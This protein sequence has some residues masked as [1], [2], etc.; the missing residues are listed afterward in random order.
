M[1]PIGSFRDLLTVLRR[2]AWLVALVLA[3]GLPLVVMFALSRPRIYEATAV[4]QIEAPEVTVTT[5]GQVLGLSADGQLDLIT[6]S[7]MARD[8]MVALIDR[9]A[10]FAE[11][12]T[13]TERV[14][15]LRE[16]IGIVKLVDPAQA[17]RPDVQPSGL[18]IT[19]RLGDQQAAADL[20]NALLD[21]IVSEARA[22]SEGRATRTLEFLLAE[23]SRVAAEIAAIETQ[24]AGYRA[25]NVASLPEGLTAQRDRLSRLSETRLALEQQLIELEGARDRLREEEVV[26]RQSLL[27]E[28]IALVTQD[29]AAIEDAIA[30]APEVERELSAMTRTLGQLEAELT[31]LTTQRTEAAMT[32]LLATQDQSE[33][34]EVL[35]RAIAPEFPVSASRR[36]IALAGGVAVALAALG[37]AVLLELLQPALRT[38]AQVERQLGVQPVIVVPRLR[39]RR[40]RLRGRLIGLG[41]LAAL[42]AAAVALLRGRWAQIPAILGL[43][44]EQAVPVRVTLHATPHH[45]TPRRA[46]Q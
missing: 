13:P 24:I 23:E 42:A 9:F 11:I 17:W 10:L 4:I 7:L 8:N 3:V 22:R 36:K 33:R 39:S 38:A 45:A 27:S 21:Q 2:K 34:F 29:I 30:A 26:S 46:R 15:L 43:Q 18:A 37:L 5:A 16:S 28:Q 1:G 25:T 20:A 40:S 44:R 31:V 6:Q 32:L 35:E 41:V 19:V 14:A 12:P